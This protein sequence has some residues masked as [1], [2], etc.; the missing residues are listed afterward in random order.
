MIVVQTCGHLQ[1]V[2]N[3]LIIISPMYKDGVIVCVCTN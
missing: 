3:V 1:E 2:L